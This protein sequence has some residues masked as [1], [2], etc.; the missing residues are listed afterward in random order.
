MGN[1]PSATDARV[2]RPYKIL[3]AVAFDATGDNALRE[4]IAHA[5]DR[6]GA[7]LHVVYVVSD[8]ALSTS[9]DALLDVDQSLANAPDELRS[10]IEKLWHQQGSVNVIGHIRPGDPAEVIL[11][12]AA[13]IDA[14]LLVLGTHNRTSLQKLLLGSVGAQVLHRAHCP[15]LIAM[16]KSHELTTTLERIEPPCPECLAVRARGANERLWCERHAKAYL[17]P[18]IYVPRDV[19]RDS[20]MPTY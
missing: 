5:V 20:L 7:E 13:E 19:P 8:S 6:R 11:Q 10:R 12:V 4:G 14:D 18:H 17:E 3:V 1:S 2:T 16:A 9:A 15:V